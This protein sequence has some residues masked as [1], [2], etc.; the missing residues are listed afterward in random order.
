MNKTILSG[1][2]AVFL[3]VPT[4][5]ITWGT[6]NSDD[7]KPYVKPAVSL[8]VLTVL[9]NAVDDEDRIKRALLIYHSGTIIESLSAG[10][11]P[12]SDA[13]KAALQ[14][15][16]PEGV[17][18]AD[19]VTS[20]DDIY[21]TAYSRVDGENGQ[22]VL[23]IVEEIAAGCRDGAGKYL[24]DHAVEIPGVVVDE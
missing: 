18:W 19:F 14:E 22:L 15:Y 11:I 21:K 5:C 7:I 1:I 24:R 16:L 2:L 17:V 10:D 12:D 23:D 6:G 20:L 9:D 8:T 13:I 3:V 4:G